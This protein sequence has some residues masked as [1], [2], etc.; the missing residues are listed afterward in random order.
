MFLCPICKNELVKCESSLKCKNNH[1]FDYA[2][3]GYVNLLNPGKRNNAKAGDSKEMIVARSMFFESGAYYKI[4]QHLC[5]VISSFQP[6]LI[7]DAGCGDG[8][9]THSVAKMNT[10]STVLGF[11]M[12]KFG[13]EH[14]AKIAKR[15]G[16]TNVHYSVANIFDLP[17]DKESANVVISLFAP[18][19]SDEFAR[20][21]KFGGHMI[22]VSAGVDHLNGLKSVLYDK[23]YPN[24]EKFLNYNSFELEKVENLKY[25]A[26]ISGID[27]INSLFT[28]TPYYHRTSLADKA[29]LNN[30]ESL[31]TTIEVNFAIYKKYKKSTSF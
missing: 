4:C 21:L 10:G 22:V 20:I 6:S 9:Y 18:V 8:Y 23:T 27:T 31:K 12:S 19:A 2:K 3:S 14:G 25:E 7:V 24:E 29:K 1:S 16:V 15:E 28:M 30:L 5:G 26:E 17:I 13:C 11:D